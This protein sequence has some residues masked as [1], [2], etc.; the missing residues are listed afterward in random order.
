MSEDRSSS[1][2]SMEGRWPADKRSRCCVEVA[3]PNSNQTGEGQQQLAH[4]SPFNNQTHNTHRYSPLGWYFHLIL[5]HTHTHPHTHCCWGE[6]GGSLPSGPNLVPANDWWL[7]AL[8]G[9]S[10]ELVIGNQFRSFRGQP[11]PPDCVTFGVVPTKKNTTSLL[12][13]PTV[14]GSN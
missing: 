8:V 10:S 4:G 11:C 3:N 12:F 14:S 9:P 5:Q 7:I 13:I 2:S 1:M 6:A